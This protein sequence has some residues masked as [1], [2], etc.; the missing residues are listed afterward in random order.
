MLAEH[1][2]PPGGEEFEPVNAR[3]PRFSLNGLRSSASRATATSQTRVGGL[4]GACQAG[5]REGVR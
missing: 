1:V 3:F 4:Q 2:Y 5:R